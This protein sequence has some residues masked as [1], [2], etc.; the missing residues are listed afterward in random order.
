MFGKEN[1]VSAALFSVI[2]EME[3]SPRLPLK[4]TM[5]PEDRENSKKELSEVYNPNLCAGIDH[6]IQMKEKQNKVNWRENSVRKEVKLWE[7]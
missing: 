2:L 6:R 4:S 1:H 5:Q 7:N 3:L